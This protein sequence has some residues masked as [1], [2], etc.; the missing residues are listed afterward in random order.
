[1]GSAPARGLLVPARLR[2]ISMV[3]Q[4]YAVWPHMTVRQ[5]VSDPLRQRKVA[6]DEIGRAVAAAALG[7]MLV[8][9]IGG[10]DM[11]VVISLLNAFT[12]LSAA[13]TGVAL[14]NPAMIVAGMIVGAS[15]TILTNLMAQ[16]MNRSVPAIVAG[17]FG[18]TVAAPVGGSG[19]SGGTVRPTSARVT[20]S[21]AKVACATAGGGFAGSRRAPLRVRGDP[22]A[23]PRPRRA[24]PPHPR[25]AAAPTGSGGPPPDSP[26]RPGARRPA[27]CRD[28]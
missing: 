1:M 16:A 5:N 28:R 3:F 9:P 24:P 27:A 26:P 20:C 23:R 8:L 10:A 2:N 14:S 6:R 11:P 17:G 4:S 25:P 19:A 15:G 13:A 21:A 12:G 18:G 22:R 7:N